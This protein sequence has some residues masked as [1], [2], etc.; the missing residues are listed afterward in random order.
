MRT[1]RRIAIA[2]IAIAFVVLIILW[3]LGGLGELGGDIGYVLLVFGI[4]VFALYLIFKAVKREAKRWP[5]ERK[6][7]EDLL[8]SSGVTKNALRQK[9]EHPLVRAIREEYFEAEKKCGNQ[10][11]HRRDE[12]PTAAQVSRTD[13][14]K[15]KENLDS[16][17]DAG[18]I[19]REEYADMKKRNR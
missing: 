15:R 13:V 19:T 2:G 1:K 17:L 7:M 10:E 16:L 11:Q 6:W 8:A 5:N 12:T 9:G 3:N 14:Q 18:L 4:P